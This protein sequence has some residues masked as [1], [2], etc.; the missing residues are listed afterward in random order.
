MPIF[1][2]NPIFAKFGAENFFWAKKCNFRRINSSG[3]KDF[4]KIK[5]MIFY[6]NIY[7][8][9]LKIIILI[10]LN[11]WIYVNICKYMDF[12]DF[13]WFLLI[14]IG[15]YSKFAIKSWELLGLRLGL[16]LGV[17]GRCWGLPVLTGLGP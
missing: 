13:Y 2:K 3:A 4:Q 15:F 7:L 9:I 10:D 12:I 8:E 5:K 6:R 17:P 16:R 11:A 1:S 14:F